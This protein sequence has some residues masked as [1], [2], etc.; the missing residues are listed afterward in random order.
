MVYNLNISQR[1]KSIDKYFTYED[2]S[3]N[4]GRPKYLTLTI[5]SRGNRRIMW[6]IQ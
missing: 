3:S 6:Q 2:I 4:K 1:S 5:N